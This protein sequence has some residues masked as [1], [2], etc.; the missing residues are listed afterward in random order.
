MMKVDK[1]RIRY[2]AGD[3][4][5]GIRVICECRKM[6]CRDMKKAQVIQKTRTHRGSMVRLEGGVL[7]VIERGFKATSPPEK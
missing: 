5:D 2:E 6:E 7:C 4:I 1:S 3:A